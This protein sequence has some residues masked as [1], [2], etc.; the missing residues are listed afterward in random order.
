MAGDAYMACE[1]N[2]HGEHVGLQAGSSRSQLSHCMRVF[3]SMRRRPSRQQR[4]PL[5][6]LTERLCMGQYFTTHPT[7]LL[8][9]SKGLK[10]SSVQRSTAAVIVKGLVPARR[11]TSVPPTHRLLE[12]HDAAG[13]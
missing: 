12:A 10:T 4:N 13:T 9:R 1:E 8:S 3:S 6:H 2:A 5:G 11:G 7:S